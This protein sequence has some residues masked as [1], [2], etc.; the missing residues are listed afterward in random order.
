MLGFNIKDMSND[1]DIEF[2]PI[3]CDYIMFYMSNED[4]ID[5]YIIDYCIM[6]EKIKLNTAYGNPIKLT[7][8]INLGK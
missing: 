3:D 5:Y 8:C 6:N 7:G 4:S 1:Y 2:C